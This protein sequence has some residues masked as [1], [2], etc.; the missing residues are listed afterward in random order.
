[1]DPFIEVCNLWRDF[2]LGLIREIQRALGAVL[3]PKYVARV[4]QRSYLALVE[5]EEKVE[6]HFEPDVSVTEPRRERIRQELRAPAPVA[7]EEMVTLRAFIEE[8]FTERF[9]DI[10]ELEPERRLVTSIEVLS[11]SNKRRGSA[12]WRKYLRK[13]QALLLGKANLV[14]LDLLRGG[15]RMPMLDPLPTSP[16]Y[17]LAA[18]AVTAPACRVW[19]AFFNRPLPM[20]PI[21][22][23]GSDPDIRLALQPLVEAIYASNRYGA[24][25]DYTRPLTPPLTAEESAWLRQR[26]RTETAPA[27]RRSR[28]RG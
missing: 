17:L 21:P 11:P 15:D 9:I 1:M 18:R 20:L 22:L 3:P 10:F 5:A 19:P 23:S 24:E 28:R 2:H 13:R 25:I 16:Y 27:K 4:G 8:D 6:R 12:G 7:E 26:L 14:E